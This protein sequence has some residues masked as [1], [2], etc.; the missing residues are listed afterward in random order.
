MITRRPSYHHTTATATSILRRYI[1]NNNR[2]GTTK[3]SSIRRLSGIQ[4]PNTDTNPVSH[5]RNSAAAASGTRRALPDDGITLTHFLQADSN[6]HNESNEMDHTMV[7]QQQHQHYANLYGSDDDEKIKRCF[8]FFLQTYGCQMNSSDS[9][10]VRSLLVNAKTNNNNTCTFEESDNLNDADIVLLNTC[11]IRENAEAKVW[12]RITEV[13]A[14]QGKGKH[15]KKHQAQKTKTKKTSKSKQVVGVL[16][17]MAERLKDKMFASGEVDLVAGPD[18]YRDL[19][20][21][22]DNLLGIAVSNKATSTQHKHSE[23]M[24]NVQLS[25][26]ETYA[27]VKPVRKNP[28]EVSAYVS[29]MRGCNNMCSYC[30]V[31]FTRGRERSREL[32]TIVDEA[33]R[34]FEEENVKEVVLLG[35]NVNSYHDRSN[36]AVLANPTSRYAAAKDFKNLYERTKVGG[37]YFADL[38]DSVSQISS[39]LRVRFTSPHPKD[40]PTELLHLMSERDNICNQLHMPAQSGSSS[41]LQRMRRGYSREAYFDLIDMVKGTIP[42]VAISSD[43]ISGFCGETEEEHR[44]T[45]SLMEHV[46]FDQAF[47]FAY[48]MRDKT[49]AHRKMADDVE[50]DVKGRRLREVIDT[51]QHLVEKKNLKEEVGKVRLVLV[52]GFSRKSTDVNPQLNGRTDQNKRIY[53]PQEDCWNQAPLLSA[54]ASAADCFPHDNNNVVQV[55]LVAGDYVAVEVTEAR[56]HTLRGRALWRTS[57]QD[58]I[59][60]SEA[61]RQHTMVPFGGN[62]AQRQVIT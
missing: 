23:N 38:L 62:G 61:E 9:D 29:V 4:E 13:R 28:N 16:G 34:L 35:Q 3:Y 21:L 14:L 24:M 33:R 32:D 58:F 40:Y 47:M 55:P 39:E 17:C 54:A 31:P 48:S 42:D 56:G 49:H 27:D 46:V 5:V 1:I 41:V 60:L 43:F 26:D 50:E 36:A 52:E 20:H 6:S 25:L 45:I 8:S 11:A 15:K 12:N 53:F 59:S 30:I 37:F 19:P 57:L 7:H 22:L 2:R 51:F 10:I 44:D 18:A